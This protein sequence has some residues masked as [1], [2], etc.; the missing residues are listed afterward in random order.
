MKFSRY[1][2]YRKGFF[3]VM[4]SFAIKTNNKNIIDYLLKNLDNSKIED[5]FYINRKFKNYENVI[6]H[7]KGNNLINFLNFISDI[8]TNCIIF[9]YEPILIKRIINFNYFYFDEVEKNIIIDNCYRYINAD[10]P[11]NYNNRKAEICNAIY[12]YISENKYMILDG[13]INF[14]LNSYL[15]IL[16]EVADYNVNQYVIEKEYTEFINLLQMYISSKIPETDLIHLIYINGESILLD[17]NKNTINIKNNILDTKYLSDISFS[18]NDYALNTLLTLL[19]K[20][21]E[22]HLIG[23]KDEFIDT[24]QLIF[25][26][27]LSICTDCNICK[28]YKILNNVNYSK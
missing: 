22:L 27:R 11:N 15:K 8:L 24:L 3:Y 23:Y 6:I 9:Y 5:I 13:F 18:S 14:R 17:E 12:D 19:P 20:K 10:N 16:D 2:I 21:I 4:K 1:Y 25:E 26:K 7:Y 28:T